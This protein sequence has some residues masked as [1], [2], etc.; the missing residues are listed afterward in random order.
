VLRERRRNEEKARPQ[1]DR[2]GI[3]H[4]LHE[5]EIIGRGRLD[6]PDPRMLVVATAPPFLRSQ[7]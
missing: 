7:D 1:A 3:G 2:A 6:R 4:T 5:E